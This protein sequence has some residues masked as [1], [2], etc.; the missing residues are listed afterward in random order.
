MKWRETNLILDNLFPKFDIIVND[1]LWLKGEKKLYVDFMWGNPTE[2]KGRP[3]LF[4]L[5][6]FH[7][8]L[9]MW[10][11]QTRFMYLLLDLG[12]DSPSYSLLNCIAQN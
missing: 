3:C 4:S 2:E 6:H 5:D 8:F 11:S 12:F 1:L 10:Q 7:A 9:A